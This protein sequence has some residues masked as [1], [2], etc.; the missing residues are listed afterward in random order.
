MLL[1][2]LTQNLSWLE[3][4]IHA[5]SCL[6]SVDE[7]LELFFLK[8]AYINI[9][10][11]IYTKQEILSCL[12]GTKW[13]TETIS[14]IFLMLQSIIACLSST[15]QTRVR[16]PNIG[17]F[18]LQNIVS[19]ILISELLEEERMNEFYNGK[20]WTFYEHLCLLFYPIVSLSFLA[21][22]P[23]LRYIYNLKY[24]SFEKA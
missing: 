7:I 6:G 5:V 2:K 23:D 1:H 12:R 18:T 15:S 9:K 8:K 4:L 13:I 11:S 21:E 10:Y 20:S 14:S 24:K 17:K 19:L 3:T 22:E 16:G